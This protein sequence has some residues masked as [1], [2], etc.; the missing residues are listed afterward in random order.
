ML[1]YYTRYGAEL[2]YINGPFYFQSE[3][4]GTS[5]YRWYAK[6]TV[7]LQ[8]GY[9]MAAWMLTG[10]TRYYYVDEGEVGPIETPKNSFGAFEFAARYSVTNLNDLDTDIKGGQSNQL[11]FGLNYYPNPNI[12]LQFN[13][14]IVNLDEFATRKGNLLGGDDHSF[15]QM[16]IQASL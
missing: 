12:K 2:M 8:G 13:Y 6:P 1:I 9:V 16:R 5:I 7:N 11:M 10:E 15:I 14:S 4:M 3:F